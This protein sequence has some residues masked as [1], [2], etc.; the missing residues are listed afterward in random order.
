MLFLKFRNPKVEIRNAD[1]S[2][3]FTPLQRSH[4][5]PASNTEELSTV[6]RPEGRAPARSSL[7]MTLAT[8]F[9]ALPLT[10]AAEPIKVGDMFPD[11]AK[12]KL[13]GKLPNDLKG[14]IVLVDFWASW[15]LPCKQSFPVL[16]ELRRRHGTN[17][18]VII[19]VNVDEQRANMEKFLKAGPVG[20]T[21]VRDAEQKLVAT[22]GVEAMPTSFL[23]DATGR[24][25][26]LHTGYLG[27]ATKKEYAR[28]IE[29]LL[30]E[31]KP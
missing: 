9:L 10:R 19:A 26:F 3:A 16:D 21:V 8:L 12:F 17:G 14:K 11:L 18:F 20:F 25:R 28:E 1:R 5:Q 27:D 6:K 23:L 30:Q 29:Q 24:V 15:C 4:G 7:V 31:K 13:E 22:A 2:A